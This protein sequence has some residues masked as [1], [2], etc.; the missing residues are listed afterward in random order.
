MD[1]PLENVFFSDDPKT[2]EIYVRRSKHEVQYGVPSQ[3]R[4]NVAH[5]ELCMRMP[6]EYIPDP[7]TVIEDA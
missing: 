3:E 2:L 6:M 4:I 1:G 5:L 7:R